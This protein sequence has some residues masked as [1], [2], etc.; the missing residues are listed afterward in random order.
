MV[1]FVARKMKNT[2]KKKFKFSVR[3][4]GLPED[5]GVCLAAVPKFRYANGECSE[6]IY[7]GCG[8]NENLF[9]TKEDCEKF[10]LNA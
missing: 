6:F 1:V 5:A 8:G 9:D 4:C 2:L 7:G 3:I 10:C